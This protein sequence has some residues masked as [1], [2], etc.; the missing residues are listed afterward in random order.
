M[1]SGNQLHVFAGVYGHQG[2]LGRR[3]IVIPSRL[4][5]IILVYDQQPDGGLSLSASSPVIAVDM[6]NR[7]D[8][9][10]DWQ[11]YRTTIHRIEQATGY[12]FLADLPADLQAHLK[13]VPTP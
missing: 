12:N 2:T 5:K 6:P 10:P 1:A 9:D 8:L 13:Q 4:W 7:S 11:R 3:G